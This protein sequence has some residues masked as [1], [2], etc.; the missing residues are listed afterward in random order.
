MNN[1]M[2]T[3][4]QNRK[5]HYLCS[6]L[7]IDREMLQTMVWNYTCKRTTHSKEMYKE[8]CQALCVHFS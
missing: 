2:R 6:R 7:G 5:L 1:V 3:P 4:E 8:E